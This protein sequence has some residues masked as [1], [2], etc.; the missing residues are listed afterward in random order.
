MLRNM[1]NFT[2]KSLG[3][4]LN[5]ALVWLIL[6]FSEFLVF[7]FVFFYLMWT[8]NLAISYWF[9]DIFLLRCIYLWLLF[10]FIYF[11]TICPVYF[12]FSS[13][14]TS[15]VIQALIF[16]LIIQKLVLVLNLISFPQ[17]QTF[18]YL[19]FPVYSAFCC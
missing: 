16:A 10:T 15:L 14:I 7:V 18:T 17:W 19:S 6:N 11:E 1:K 3:I 9:L 12:I 4:S 13:P 8:F 5:Q 2:H